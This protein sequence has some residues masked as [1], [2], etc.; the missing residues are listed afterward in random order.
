MEK[1]SKLKSK[2]VKL[3]VG[4]HAASPVFFLS[5]PPSPRKGLTNQI[6]SIIPAEARRKPKNG[7]FETRE[8]D[9]PKVSCL[10]RV[11]DKKK[12]K[13]RRKPKS[14][15]LCLPLQEKVHVSS[16]TTEEVKKKKKKQQWNLKMC[17]NGEAVDGFDDMPAVLDRDTAPSLAQMKTFSSARGGFEWTTHLSLSSNCEND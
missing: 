17:R 12:K 16:V 1:V 2:I 8:P 5:P 13:K 11:N 10:G 4:S 6:V 3:L 15:L 7:S 14:K 9:S